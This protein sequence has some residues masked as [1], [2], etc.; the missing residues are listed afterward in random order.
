M[1]LSYISLFAQEENY[2]HINN[3][4]VPLQV[5]E[6]NLVKRINIKHYIL[7]RKHLNPVKKWI[8]FVVRLTIILRGIMSVKMVLYF[9]A[10]TV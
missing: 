8:I 1:L 10:G 3:K 4:I 9:Y 6:T 2:R 5:I 7:I